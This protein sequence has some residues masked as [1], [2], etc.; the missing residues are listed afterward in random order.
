[1]GRL[2]QIRRNNLLK[3]ERRV[4][5]KGISP[6][7]GEKVTPENRWD[8]INK[9]GEAYYD[10]YE[11]GRKEEDKKIEAGTLAVEDRT[12]TMTDDELYETSILH[13]KETVQRKNKEYKAWLKGKETYTFKGKQFSVI[14]QSFLLENERMQEIMRQREAETNKNKDEQ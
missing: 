4:L 14:T 10:M 13:G 7:A 6:Y 5:S 8:L 3:K 12:F 11:S 9:H 2:R 1:M